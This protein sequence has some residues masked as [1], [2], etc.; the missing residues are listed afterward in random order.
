VDGRGE[1]S[2][3]I[4]ILIDAGVAVEEVKRVGIPLEEEFLALMRE[5]EAT[6]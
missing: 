1:I 4:P 5:S 2:S 6:R 3:L